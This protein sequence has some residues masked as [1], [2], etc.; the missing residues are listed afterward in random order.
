MKIF[1][2]ILSILLTIDCFSQK[3]DL[4]NSTHELLYDGDSIK[5]KQLITMIHEQDANLI[6]DKQEIC[7]LRIKDIGIY[8]KL[9]IQIIQINMGVGISCRGVY[10]TVF[11]KSGQYLGYY[12][13]DIAEPKI[14][15]D[16]NLIWEFENN[17]TVNMD[18]SKGVPT[19][20]KFDGIKRELTK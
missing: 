4:E 10:R 2:I 9:N 16:E 7:E 15:K 20:F 13:S 14:L 3:S 18:L 6:P 11:I 17:K 19:K 8:D 1:L 5:L 12:N